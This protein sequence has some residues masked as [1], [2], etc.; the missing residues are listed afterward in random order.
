MDIFNKQSFYER[1][2]QE[3]STQFCVKCVLILKER[4][5]NGEVKLILP[6][7]QKNKITQTTGIMG[8]P[9]GAGVQTRRERYAD[10]IV[11]TIFAI[12][13]LPSCFSPNEP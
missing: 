9:Q 11:Q 10:A 8:T 1:E 12:V 6:Y 2:A 7:S 4:Q 3:H 5:K 13:I